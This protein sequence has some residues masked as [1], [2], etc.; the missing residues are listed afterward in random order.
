MKTMFVTALAAGLA[1]ASGTDAAYAKDPEGVAPSHFVCYRVSQQTRLPPTAV[2]LKDQ[3]VGFG[4][5]VGPA[6]LLCAP[7]DKNGEG[8]KDEKTHLTCYTISAKNA[9][10]T[11][12]VQNQFGEQKLRVGGSVTLCVPSLK[13]VL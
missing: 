6:A 11:V 1:I 3:F 9:G 4:T 5:R 13:K 12:A 10:K 2:K 8:I 7:V